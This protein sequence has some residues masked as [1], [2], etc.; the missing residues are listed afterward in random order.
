LLTRWLPRNRISRDYL[1]DVDDKIREPY[2]VEFVSSACMVFPRRLTEKI[3]YW[4]EE[5][6]GYWVDADWCKR[7]HAFGP[8]YCLPMVTV[9][10][11]EQNRR[12]VRKGTAR[13]LLFH[14]GV[15]RFYRKHYTAGWL[16]PRAIAAAVLLYGRAA[17]LMVV[18]RFLPPPQS[19]DPQAARSIAVGAGE[20]N[21]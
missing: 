1:G 5:F 2:P 3:G 4:D 17:T 11:F 7:A 12:G 13:I 19:T 10:H 16:D 6:R 9:V 15:N 14:E 8:V 20:R 21:Q 18:D